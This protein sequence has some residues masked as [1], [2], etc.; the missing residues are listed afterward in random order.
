MAPEPTSPPTG[1]S[2]ARAVPPATGP[3]TAPPVP[4]GRHARRPRWRRREPADAPTPEPR[5]FSDDGLP[6]FV[7][8]HGDFVACSYA[9]CGALRLVEDVAAKA[10]CSACGRL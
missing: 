6:V 2:A 4:A 5:I 3:A 8:P 1:L 9:G 10:P 7:V